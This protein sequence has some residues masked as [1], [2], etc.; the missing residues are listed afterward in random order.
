MLAAI[1]NPVTAILLCT[2]FHATNIGAGAGFGHGERIKFLTFNRRD[3][4]LLA[5]L[6]GAGLQ[7]AGGTAEEY[8]QPVGGTAKFTFQQGEVKMAK[9]TTAKFLGDI[10]G[11]VA[12]LDTFVPNFMTDFRRSFP[13]QN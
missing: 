11:E 9:T 13:V 3:Q 6:F 5:L 2:A 4:V 1:H 8:R 10:G 7:N 12:R